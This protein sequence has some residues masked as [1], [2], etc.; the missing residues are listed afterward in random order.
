[1]LAMA[2]SLSVG[3]VSGPAVLLS[4]PARAFSDQDDHM[5]HTLNCKTD[6]RQARNAEDEENQKRSAKGGEQK[7]LNKKKQARRPA[8]SVP[9][10]QLI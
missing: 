9:T 3:L 5:P 6:K 1:M 8:F 10:T 2:N 7:R 4:P